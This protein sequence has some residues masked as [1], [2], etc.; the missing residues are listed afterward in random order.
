VH[1]KVGKAVFSMVLRDKQMIIESAGELSEEIG[2]DMEIVKTVAEIALNSY[3]PDKV[4]INKSHGS[5]LL[6]VKKLIRKA[7]PDF[8]VEI[9]DNLF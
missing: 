4:G 7:F 8:P 1:K 9:V 2:V 6:A 3:N 5:I